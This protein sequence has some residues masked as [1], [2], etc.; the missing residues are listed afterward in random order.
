MKISF[1][2]AG[3]VGIALAAFMREKGVVPCAIV[4]RSDASRERAKH[5]LPDVPAVSNI[6]ELPKSDVIFITV[7]DREIASAAGS[8]RARFPD[9]VLV[10]TSGAHPSSIIPGRGRASCH[11]L[12]SL[13]DVENAVEILPHSLFTVE[14]DE[15]GLSVLK[16]LLKALNLRFVEIDVSSKPLY[17][18]AAVV[19]S[20]YLVTLMYQALGIM[21]LSGFP[22]EE[23]LEGLVALAEGTLKNI[24]KKGVPDALTGPIS[25][26]DW[27]TVEL[28]LEKLRINNSLRQFYQYMAELTRKM[29]ES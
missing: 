26:G 8:L 17:H 11:P 9:A 2:G 10:H 22:E 28:H 16:D 24:K 5:Y 20:N 23:G 6:S 1:V 7:P 14:G 29:I 25:R 19:A 12:Q 3:R 13:A 18:A 21:K 27:E 4:A 15:K